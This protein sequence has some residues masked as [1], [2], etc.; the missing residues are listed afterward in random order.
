MTGKLQG[1][2]KEEEG[3]GA[4]AGWEE[5]GDPAGEAIRGVPG[6]RGSSRKWGVATFT[7]GEA[8]TVVMGLLVFSKEK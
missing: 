3:D 4:I 7:K 2:A 1:Q 6:K 5:G 8:K